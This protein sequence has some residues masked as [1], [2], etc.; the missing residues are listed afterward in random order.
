MGI[1]RC[2][3]MKTI[4]LKLPESLDKQICWEARRRGTTK[5]KVVRNAIESYVK[6]RP[7]KVKGS[8][9]ELAGDLIGSLEGPS[10]LS[11]NKKY[12]EGFGE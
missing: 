7:A 12:M 1:T 10:D 4:S 8:W 3:S 2:K 5:S 9:L 6:Q 11:T